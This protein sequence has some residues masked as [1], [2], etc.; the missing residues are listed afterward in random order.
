MSEEQSTPE[1]VD[2]IKAA[3]TEVDAEIDAEE[4]AAAAKAAE[5]KVTCYLSKRSVPKSE[6][7]EMMY[8]GEGPFRVQ[9]HLVKF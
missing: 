7:V 3:E 6:T 2:A 5:E 9:E 4:A 1:E 8:N